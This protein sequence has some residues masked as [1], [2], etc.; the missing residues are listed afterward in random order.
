MSYKPLSKYFYE[1][2]DAYQAAYAERFNSDNSHHLDFQIGNAP[3]FFLITEEVRRSIARIN[4]FSARL[5]RLLEILPGVAINH[6]TVNSLIDEIILTNNIEGVH[7]TRREIEDVMDALAKNDR[8]KRFSG[9]VQK[10]DLLKTAHDLP[11]QI[12]EDI[13][14]IYD[15]L[16]LSEVREDDEDNVPDGKIFR[17]D[18]AFVTSKTQKVIHR[19]VYPEEKI[20]SCM[21]NALIFLNEKKHHILVRISIFHYLFGYIHPFY[22]GNGRTS[23]FISSYLL[24]KEFAPLAGYRLS[25]AIKE[26]IDSYY[27]AFVICNDPKNRGDV[28]P[29]LI[30]FLEMIEH[31]MEQL[32]SALQK[33]LDRW[34]YYLGQCK[35]MLDLDK[36]M[37][38]LFDLLIQA[39][40]FGEKGITILELCY[41]MKIDR[42]TLSMYLDRIPS[43]DLLVVRIENEK[44]FFSLDISLID[45]MIMEAMLE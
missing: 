18:I 33:R 30:M 22:D 26:S 5:K 10:Y 17:K 9:L 27:K 12:P 41:Y 7:S 14:T 29:F 44:E 4:T 11:L 36:T 19:G 34:A 40:L 39:S 31:S 25:Y 43:S 21:E 28:T 24:S 32:I 1:G 20:I 45:S 35:E 3:A 38:R 6:F 8:K 37:S 23:R 42:P 15:E 2:Q 13:R 16:V